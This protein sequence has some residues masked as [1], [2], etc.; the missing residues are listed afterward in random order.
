MEQKQSKVT[1]ANFWKEN[2]GQYGK[3]YAHIVKMENGDEGVYNSKSQN[4]DKFVVGSMVSYQWQPPKPDKKL[5]V[6]KPVRQQDG[7]S[8]QSQQEKPSQPTTHSVGNKQSNVSL[9][10][11]KEAAHI[12]KD[13]VVGRGEESGDNFGKYFD[14][15]LKKMR[16]GYKG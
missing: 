4:Q 8:Q 12:A 11:I 15:V 10:M 1:E 16:E 5:G 2:D 6:I 13:I 7:S 14:G 3:L 9:E